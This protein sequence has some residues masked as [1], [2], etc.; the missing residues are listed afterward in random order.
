M[1]GNKIII[2]GLIAVG[3][4]TLTYPQTLSAVGFCRDP[5]KCGRPK[6]KCDQAAL[7][8][9]KAEF[10]QAMADYRNHTSQEKED[11]AKADQA[12]KE[13]DELF[14]EVFSIPEAGTMGVELGEHIIFE[15]V[16]KHGSGEALAEG[17]ASTASGVSV[18]ILLGKLIFLD[19]K[20]VGYLRELDE[21]SERGLEDHE[22]AIEDLRR[23]REA[24]DK[25]DELAK[26]CQAGQPSD[27]KSDT[28]SKEDQEWKSSGQREAELAQKLLGSWK[29]VAGGYEDAKGDFHDADLAF[30]QA[31]AIVQSQQQSSTNRGIFTVAHRVMA[32]NVAA[33]GSNSPLSATQKAK[34]VPML[35]RG[36]EFIAKSGKAIEGIRTQ[37]DQIKAIYAQLT[38]A[39][40]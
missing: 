33:Q 16:I 9:A 28:S 22:K 18:G 31:L 38:L 10:Q 32:Q 40:T 21:Y 25:M 8:K 26:Q 23:A 2:L 27:K 12:Y 15:W 7:D 11:Y 35:A 5:D 3:L 36:F 1:R 29:K 34:V 24:H 19:S 4:L 13:A 17:F 37:L 14:R 30:Q 20:M 39:G 6:Q